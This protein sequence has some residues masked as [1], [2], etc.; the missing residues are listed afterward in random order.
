M[1]TEVMTEGAALAGEDA[2]TASAGFPSAVYAWTVV[3]ALSLTNM[4]SYVERQILTLLFTPIKH[5][6]HLNDTQVSLLAG[7]AF[8]LFYVA[9]GLVIGRLADRSNRKRIIM[10]GVVFWSL[11]T[12]AC[13]FAQN[14]IQLFVARISVGVGEA[15][16]GPSAM[17]IISDYFPRPRLARALSVFTGSQ[18]VGAGLALVVG[19]AAISAA[20]SLSAHH[21]APSGLRPWQ[22]AFIFVGLGGLLVL[23]PLAFMKEPA[24]RGLARPRTAAVGRSE[25]IAFFAENKRLL[26][27]HFAA[28]SISSMVGFGAVAW[29]P[30]FFV[31]V[32]HWTPQSIGYVYGLMLAGLGGAGV[33]AGARVGEWMERRGVV[34]AYLRVPI[35]SMVGA[36]VL[37]IGAVLAPDQRLAL[38]LLAGSTFISSFPVALIAAVLQTVTPNQMRGQVV[39]MFN[40]LSNVLGVASGPT[41][42]ALLTDFVF[43]RE[44]AVGLSLITVTAVITPLVVVILV[45]GLRGY[46]ESLAR[47]PSLIPDPN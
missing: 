2:A 1:I 7:A 20:A 11:A 33:L 6:F 30:T 10:V 35:F 45:I 46:R 40:F 5:D 36:G 26:I 16:L 43:R 32:H 41:V 19:G 27:C 13:G 21:L 44:N 22:L 39:S 4:M 8:V 14:F 34:D 28:F 9:F 37:L 3:A 24:R 47:A 25:L 15:T 23:I 12:T 17:S 18:Y 42:V 38:I 29:V 31:R